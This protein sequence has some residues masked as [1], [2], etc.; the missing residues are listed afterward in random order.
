MD[1]IMEELVRLAQENG[2][3]LSMIDALHRIVDD[4][5][6][7]KAANIIGGDIKPELIRNI[8]GWKK[9]DRA[10][11]ALIEREAWYKAH[12]KRLLDERVDE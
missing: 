3:L 7:S 2:Q 9:C 6:T 10:K 12:R 4:A 1:E 5:E 8:F 11:N